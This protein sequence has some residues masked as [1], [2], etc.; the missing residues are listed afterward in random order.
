LIH[1]RFPGPLRFGDLTT[2][3]VEGFW[4]GEMARAMQCDLVYGIF[5]WQL[6]IEDR[7]ME[8]AERELWRKR[9]SR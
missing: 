5:P 9:Y 7:A 6:S 4:L 3:G 8:L 1:G 2:E